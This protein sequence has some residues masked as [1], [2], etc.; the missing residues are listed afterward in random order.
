MGHG[1]KGPFEIKDGDTTCN[2]FVCPDGLLVAGPGFARRA[3]GVV[4]DV[5][6]EMIGLGGDGIIGAL[7]LGA[8]SA[9]VE[10]T[11]D[12]AEKAAAQASGKAERKE[13]ALRGITERTSSA[14]DLA[15]E[16]LTGLF[17]NSGAL[18]SYAHS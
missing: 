3:R 4:I 5:G 9:T 8:V 12:G 18:W 6:L 16:A 1:C 2:L 17:M 11:V 10:A 14:A 15:G 7:V 13:R